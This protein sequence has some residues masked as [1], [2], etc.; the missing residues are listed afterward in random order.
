MRVSLTL[1]VLLALAPSPGGAVSRQPDAISRL[2]VSLEEA[3]RAGSPDKLAPLVAD[4]AVTGKFAALMRGPRKDAVVR[5][6]DR[7]PGAGGEVDLLL[8]TFVERGASGQ[9]GTWRVTLKPVPG[10]SESWRFT[11]F[12]ELSA[13]DGLYRLSLGTQAFDA[14]GLTLT[15]TDF[16]VQMRTGLAFVAEAQGGPTAIVLRG[17][18]EMTFTPQDPAEQRQVEILSKST[19]LRVPFEEAFIRLNP[20][21]IERRLGGQALTPRASTPG[22]Y[23]AALEVFE[24]FTG[25]TYTLD[26]QDLSRERWSLVP[27][28]GDTVAEVRTKKFGVLT[29][30]QSAGEAEDI[31]L[32]QREQRRNIAVYPSA[33]Q[34][35]TRGRFYSEDAL[36]D[37]DIEHHDIDVRFTPAREWIDGTAR[38]RARVRRPQLSTV[39]LR[40]AESLVVRS[41]VAKGHGRLMHLR[42]IGQNNLIV[43]LPSPAVRGDLLDLEVRYGGRLAAQVLDREAITVSAPQEMDPVIIPPE[44]RWIYSNRSYWY[45]QSPV[46]DFATARVR[47]SVPQPLDV[48]ATGIQVGGPEPAEDPSPASASR[49]FTFESKQPARY[50]SCVISKFV[51]VVSRSIPGGSGAT[52]NVISSPRQTGRAR[53]VADQAEQIFNFYRSLTGGAPYPQLTV[54]VSESDLPGGHSPAYFVLLNQTLPSATV[55][56]R[57]DPVSFENF[58]AFFIAHEIAHQWWGQSVGWKNYH[59]QWISEG[60]SQYFAALYAGEQRGP[61]ALANLMRQ[62]RRW[63]LE[64]SGQ[65]PIYLGYRLGHVQGDSRVFRSLVYN[66]GA[67]VLHMLRRLVGDERFFAGIR[68]FYEQSKFGKAGTDDFR[69]VM[70]A[71]T[72]QNLERFFDRWIY[73]FGVP[74][75]KVTHQ[76]ETKPGGEHELVIR[77]SQSEAVYDLPITIAFE[78]ENGA[79]REVLL[80]LTDRSAELRVPLDSAAGKVRRVEVDSDAAALARF[81]R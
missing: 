30:A 61:A 68:K 39:T 19:S 13:V 45:P 63:A 6:R 41:V 75:V 32:F 27:A 50:L 4:G 35:A 53:A 74:A 31:S 52:L 70:E 28:F 17:R 55:T 56:W 3:L 78:Q 7:N 67:V 36:A 64:E 26:L 76:V 16:S 18:G 38:L 47:I 69:R 11:A 57:A 60:F 10:P 40:L 54:A 24:H 5:E 34:L 72:G 12:E 80:L 43:T 46:T 66:K 2:V 25:K 15:A 42:V 79:R 14:R 20:G 73:G 37:Y 44:P 81:V 62:M 23:R 48:V 8:D 9:I 65:G 49:A 1:I 33:T 21:E 22:D 71:E 77:A 29:Y 51:P 58:P 59:E